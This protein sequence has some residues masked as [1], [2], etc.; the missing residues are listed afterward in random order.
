MTRSLS[1]LITTIEHF[2]FG[3]RRTLLAGFAV[4]TLLMGYFVTQLRVDTGFEKLLP[5]EH[6]YM[7]IFTQYQDEFGGANRILIALIVKEGDIFTPEFFEKLKAVTDEAFFIP[8]MDRTKVRSIF[9][10]NVRFIEIVEDGFAGGNVIPADFRPTPEGLEQVRINILKSGQVGR[11]VANDFRGAM[12]SAELL[13]V[14]PATGAR[15][16]YIDVARRLE[17]TIREKYVSDNVDIHVIGFAKV[18]GDI[19]DGARSVMIFF[20]VAFVITALLVYV[21]SRSIRLTLL[22]LACSL[23]AVVW[24]LGL[25]PMLGFGIDPMS[26]LIP[27]LVFAIGVSH[28]V[29]MINS[30]RAEIFSGLD[31][32]SAARNSFRR[33]LIPG[34]V[35]LIS[36]TIGFLTILLIKIEIIQE[37]AITASLGVAVIILTNLFLLPILLSYTGIQ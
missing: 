31:S 11:L 1:S 6:E 20:L 35:A 16:D 36:D 30:V 23:V 29:Q 9:T 26:I 37:M 4:L 10:P 27:F 33:L 17:Q 34:G 25:L 21:Y 14:D 19:A 3:H 15:L 5:L 7:K 18:V 12:I 22:P 13:E 32:M 2:V 28:G 8:G 24:Q